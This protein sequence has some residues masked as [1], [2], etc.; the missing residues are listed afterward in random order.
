M[1]QVDD[2]GEDAAR[3]N[4]SMAERKAARDK[5]RELIQNPEIRMVLHEPAGLA[6]EM[7]LVKH[8]FRSGVKAQ[9]G[10]EWQA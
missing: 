9:F 4:A 1:S 10:M 3:H 6:T 2:H 8:R 5:A 7:E